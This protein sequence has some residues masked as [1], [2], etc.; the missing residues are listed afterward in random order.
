MSEGFSDHDVTSVDRKK[1]HIDLALAS[2]VNAQSLDDRFFYEPVLSGHPK[3]ELEE[4]TRL[5]KTFKAPIWV[6]SM[7]GGTEKARK[8]NTNLAKACK[9]FG[10]GMGLGSCRGLL[11]S[12]EF[13]GDFNM[14]QYIGDQPLY[15]N[16]GI[17]QVES[18]VSTGEVFKIVELVNKLEAN[19]LIIHIN[20]M[21]EWLQPEGDRYY[22]SPLTT[23]SRI[24]DQTNLSLII[25]EVGQGMGPESLDAL[26]RL[27][28]QAI[29]F[30]A[31]GGTNFSKVEI[32]R[33][34]PENNEAYEDLVFIGHS[35]ESMT[36]MV[37]ALVGKYGE[38]YHCKEIIISGG[39]AGFLDGYYLTE[40]SVLP[41][42]YGQASAMLKNAQG[43]YSRIQEYV[44]RQIEGL[45]LSKAFLKIKKKG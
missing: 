3:G 8:I 7:T 27:P 17:A 23:I 19:G 24:L 45:K 37:N 29:D 9:E 1:H 38:E 15:A 43:D 22:E 4:V 25:K 6:S 11:S 40:L 20:P 32:L 12:D 21:Q 34:R 10:L 18:L 31:N 35:A 39:V 36:E 42:L 5:G 16:L 14:R 26:L 41:A 33:G 30:G 28:I 2:Q 13:F 44:H